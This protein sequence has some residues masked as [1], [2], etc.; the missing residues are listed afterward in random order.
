[1]CWLRQ[2][3]GEDPA[4]PQYIETLRGYGHRFVTDPA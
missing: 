4:V 2:K 3:L 1:M